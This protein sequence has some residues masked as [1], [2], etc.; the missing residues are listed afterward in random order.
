MRFSNSNRVAATWNDT[1]VYL[2]SDMVP[3]YW[4]CAETFAPVFIIKQAE[5]HFFQ[6][7]D[8][9]YYITTDNTKALEDTLSRFQGVSE[10]YDVGKVVHFG[11]RKN[12]GYKDK[13]KVIIDNHLM[14]N[15]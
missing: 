9:H 11:K 4:Q 10:H 15:H 12:G 8:V 3:K 14:G 5:S 6:A 7:K 2:T 1:E 13:Q